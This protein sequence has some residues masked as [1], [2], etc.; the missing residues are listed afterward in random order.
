MSHKLSIKSLIFTSLFLISPSVLAATSLF[1]I[2][3]QDQSMLYLSYIFGNVGD[4]LAGSN[5]T[6]LQLVL[7]YF[8]NAVLVLG[9]I[10]IIYSSIVG[11]IN[12]AHEG[13]MLGKNW[14]NPWV[15]LRAALGFA[16]LL[17]VKAKSYALIQVFFMWIV[18]QG[19][20]AADYI[21]SQ[22]VG[23]F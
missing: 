21:W 18:I 7:V 22:G 19:V 16:L 1:D 8:N 9:G 12:M 4:I 5:N 11:T 13:E 10:V 20:G 2:P 23:V 6:L 15:P 3:P 14:N 17:P